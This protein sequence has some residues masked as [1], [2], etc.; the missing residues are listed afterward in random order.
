LFILFNFPDIQFLSNSTVFYQAS[1][2]LRE[3]QEIQPFRR[4]SAA[5]SSSESS[6]SVRN[7][8]KLRV[9]KQRDVV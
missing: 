5:R 4:E 1:P 9:F 8:R 6:K 3:I 2:T 7:P